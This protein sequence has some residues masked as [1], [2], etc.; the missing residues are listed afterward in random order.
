MIILFPEITFLKPR[1]QK[2]HFSNTVSEFHYTHSEKLGDAFEFLLSILGTQGDA[3]QFRTPRHIIDFIAECVNP[4]KGDTICD[5][6]CGT[7]GFVISASQPEALSVAT[8]ELF[9][10]IS[11]FSADEV[12]LPLVR[13]A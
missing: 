11:N 10:R 13:A 1:S 8:T 6:A 3:G 2:Y 7:A 9:K 4:Q 5:P 12:P